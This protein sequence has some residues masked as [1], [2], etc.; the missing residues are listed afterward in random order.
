[1]KW[2]VTYPPMDIGTYPPVDLQQVQ[3]EILLTFLKI[4]LTF[5]IFSNNL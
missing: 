1:M 4:L 2:F 3:N 5:G